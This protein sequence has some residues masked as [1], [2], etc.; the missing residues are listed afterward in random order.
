VGLQRIVQ[1]INKS[2]QF[3]LTTRRYTTDQVAEVMNDPSA[4]GLQLRL[5]DRFGDNGVIAIIIGRVS[6]RQLYLD[7]WIMSCRVLGRQVEQATLS[8]I[9]SE[10]KRLGV[11]AVV[12]EY[13][14]TAKNGM[15]QRH[16][17]NLGFTVSSESEDGKSTSV[18]ALSQYE[19]V[20]TFIDI[21][22]G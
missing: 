1:L 18:L 19:V 17:P 21:V 2:N 20:P 4:I 8:V 7:T 13:I 5:I 15:V 11:G 22:K 10:A 14:P 6:D 12:G 3:N 16:Y 9:M